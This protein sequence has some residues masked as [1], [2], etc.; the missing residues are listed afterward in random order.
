MTEEHNYV[1][2]GQRLILFWPFLT[3]RVLFYQMNVNLF[4]DFKLAA[5]DFF[6]FHWCKMINSNANLSFNRTS[7][8]RLT[9]A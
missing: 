3:T 1:V 4:V 7:S 6:K 5:C 8:L 9:A 2:A